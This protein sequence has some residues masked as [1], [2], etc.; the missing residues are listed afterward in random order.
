M[1]LIKE[2]GGVKA[3]ERGIRLEMVG[4][5]ERY[6]VANTL[7]SRHIEIEHTETPDGPA[8]PGLRLRHERLIRDLTSERL[9]R[10]GA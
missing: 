5:R 4:F 10:E 6:H 1:E 8:R 3:P 7:D 2:F 9:G